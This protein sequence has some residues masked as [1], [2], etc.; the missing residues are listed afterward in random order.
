MHEPYFDQISIACI[1][2]WTEQSAQAMLK[3]V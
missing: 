2:I 3:V 1:S